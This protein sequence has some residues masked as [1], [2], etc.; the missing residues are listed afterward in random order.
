MLSELI[1]VPTEWGFVELRL[2]ALVRASSDT[3]GLKGLGGDPSEGATWSDVVISETSQ[4]ANM[5]TGW[6]G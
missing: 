2:L 6:E 1:Q 4:L 3:E 5:G